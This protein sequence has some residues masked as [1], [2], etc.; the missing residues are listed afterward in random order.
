MSVHFSG[1]IHCPLSGAMSAPTNQAMRQTLEALVDKYKP[2]TK[3]DGRDYDIFL[4]LD[5]QGQ[6]YATI[7][8]PEQHAKT[9][10]LKH[11]SQHPVMRFLR[12]LG[13][14]VLNRFMTPRSGEEKMVLKAIQIARTPQSVRL[15]VEELEPRNSF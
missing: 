4:Q 14:P 2:S 7:E 13:A 10:Y 9:V 5:Q 15:F 6:P 12:T 3:A 11:P 8:I 1:N